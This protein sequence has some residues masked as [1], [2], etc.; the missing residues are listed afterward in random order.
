[1][2]HRSCVQLFTTAA[3]YGKC[4]FRFESIAISV[5]DLVSALKV[6]GHTSDLVC[7]DCDLS[8][9]EAKTKKLGSKKINRKTDYN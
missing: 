6:V 1:M 8:A 2:T 7:I 5:N 3:D 4:E 9:F